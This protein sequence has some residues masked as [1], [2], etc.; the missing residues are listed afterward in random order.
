MDF[1]N[2]ESTVMELIINAGESR[3]CA[4]QAL[5]EA[6]KGHWDE[7]EGLLKQSK[8][9]AK[10]AHDVQTQLIGADEGEG[11]LPINLIMVH[12]QDHIMTAMLARDLVVELIDVYKKLDNAGIR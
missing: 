12:A 9:A 11:K 7:S 6:K 1:N 10:L 2:M 4:M 5:F 8:E 3:S